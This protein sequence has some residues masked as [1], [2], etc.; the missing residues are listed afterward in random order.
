LHKEIKKISLNDKT[1]K[2]TSQKN[3]IL[4]FCGVIYCISIVTGGFMSSTICMDG[5]VLLG[6]L[7]VLRFC[8]HILT[9]MY[10]MFIGNYTH[11]ILKRFMKKMPSKRSSIS[12]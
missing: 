10:Y 3:Y 12:Q 6:L 1:T 5:W 7:T 4:G 9:V 2:L 8:E 11:K